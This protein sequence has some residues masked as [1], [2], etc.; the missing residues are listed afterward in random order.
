MNAM[1]LVV[2]NIC[3][4]HTVFG[5]K[6]GESQNLEMSRDYVGTSGEQVMGGSASN[7]A[8]QARQ[9]GMQVG[10]VSKTG[11]DEE[12]QKLRQMLRDRG[13]LGDLV[14]EDP[15]LDTLMRLNLVGEDGQYVGINYGNASRTLCAKDIDL[16]NPLFD[17]AAGVYFG[18][19][20]KQKQLFADC[21]E[22]FAKL[23]QRGIKVFYDTNRFPPDSSEAHVALFKKQLAYVEGYFPNE[24]ELLQATGGQSVDEA[25]GVAIAAGVHFV[26]LKMGPK[27]CRIKTKQDDFVVGG[28]RVEVVTTVGAGDSF[29]ATFINYYLAGRSLKECAELATTAAS[30]RVSRNT[31]PTKVDVETANTLMLQSNS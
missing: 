2:G 25:L 8:M 31:W 28:R 22:L 1:L 15:T 13:I 17:R 21:E 16:G 19:T 10:L 11:V 12:A 20:A 4:D 30:I 3:I 26:A 27:G 9:L 14:T 29:N 24:A 7:V 5:I 23:S 18:G 6:T